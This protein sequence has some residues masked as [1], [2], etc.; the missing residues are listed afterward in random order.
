ML[1]YF[2]G[3]PLAML[4]T[5]AF[6]RFLE[7][8]GPGRWSTATAL[9]SLAFLVHLTT[10]MLLVPAC[11]LAYI[12]AIRWRGR[13]TPM[14]WR[15]HVAVLVI[16]VV[17][18]VVNAF[19]WYPGLFL[20]STKGDSSFAFSHS[21]EGVIERM[22]KILWTEAPIQ[23][24]LLGAGL[25]GLVLLTRR[26]NVAGAALAGFVAAG[27][28]WGYL[29]G[30]AGSLDFLQPGRHTFALYSGLSI[31]GAIA[32]IEASR[33]I[34]EAAAGGVILA[35]GFVAALLLIG[36]RI[37]G[38]TL[39]DSVYGHLWAGEPFLSSR[40][41]PRLLWVMDRVGRYVKPGERLLYEEG[42]KDLPRVPDP[43]RRGRFSGLLPQRTGVELIGGPYLHAALTTNFTQFG[44]G[45]L[46]GRA[47][48]DRGFFV[49]YARLYRP[50]AI[51]CWSPHARAF[52]RAN[53]DL[54]RILEDDGSLLIGRVEGFGGDTIRGQ[55][56]VVASPGRLRVTGIVPDLDGSVVLRY[57][58][59]PCLTTR[60][61]VACEPEFQEED[62]VPFI[63]LR[64]PPGISDVELQ[65]T[66]PGRP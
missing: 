1:P 51:L 61:S 7:R 33:R 41:S 46:F 36:I 24:M 55:A 58:F 56:R 53:P 28:G 26:S 59:V 8:R 45:R 64:P 6:V 17:V 43:Y 65:M 40:P 9:L 52:C 16:P 35:L 42:G 18:M 47:D 63:R 22:A 34:W 23:A 4:A 54:I 39:V 12:A 11:L 19:W 66:F 25:S 44:E 10:A 2:L 14:T 30:A 31:A 60:S 62:P 20:A 21:G 5:S 29:A 37:V 3:V 13:A 27:L 50:S 49:R 32:V 15:G 48:W 38:P 57:H